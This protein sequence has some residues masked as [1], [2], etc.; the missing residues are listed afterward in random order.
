MPLWYK[1]T[2]HRR[3]D[4]RLLEGIFLPLLLH[5]LLLLNIGLQYFLRQSFPQSRF[6]DG[7]DSTSFIS[8]LCSTAG[9]SAFTTGF[10]DLERNSFR[11]P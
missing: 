2:T 5:A 11:F 9:T 3:P 7:E 6:L 4:H 8:Q 10:S 1:H